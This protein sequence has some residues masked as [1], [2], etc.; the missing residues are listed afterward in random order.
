MKL[1]I[2]MGHHKVGSTSL[3][4]F[5]SQNY[6]GLLKAGILYPSVESQGFSHNIAAAL[7]GADFEGDLPINV[8]EPHNALAF[9]MIADVAHGTV[10]PFHKNLPHFRKMFVAIN[11]QIA[12][13]K[14]RAM[15]LCGE[16]L[17]NFAA[18]DV[19]LIELLKT[20]FD[21]SDVTIVATLRRPDDY[22]I[23]W[24][25]QRLKFGHTVAA[26]RDDAVGQYARS[27]HFDYQLMLEAWTEVFDT[28]RFVVRDY[29][30][31]RASGGSVEDFLQHSGLKFPE[32]LRRFSDA[33]PSIPTSLMEIARRANHALPEPQARRVRKFL[34]G[35]SDKLSLPP[36]H[37]V[38]MFGAENRQNLA[39]Q[40]EAA[41]SFLCASFS[42]RG[43]GQF[44]ADFDKIT[45]IKPLPE[46]DAAN[47]ALA[48]V[49]KILSDSDLS[50]EGR[51]FIAGLSL[52]A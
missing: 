49:K 25:G 18:A 11:E 12:T 41:N 38:E 39:W 50:P 51:A 33:N 17:S 23:S 19:R 26:L 14:P 24:H 27:I 4:R 6:L 45:Q 48:Q 1:V 31:I 34:M 22:L 32:N 43:D 42:E 52:G 46:L 28:A 8:R 36:N 35:L 5:L 7:N 37:D 3:Q 29:S 44:F 2:F 16:V 40:F 21:V 9:R 47:D 30:D 20:A 13:L 10:P 15:I